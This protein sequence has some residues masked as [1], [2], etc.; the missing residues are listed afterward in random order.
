MQQQITEHQPT[1]RKGGERQSEHL[2][3]W[4]GG[5]RLQN[6]RKEEGTGV[7]RIGRRQAPKGSVPSLPGHFECWS[8][9]TVPEAGVRG[10][11]SVGRGALVCEPRLSGTAASGS[12]GD[13][14]ASFLDHLNNHDLDLE[15]DF[16]LVQMT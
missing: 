5:G 2:R 12:R 14:A 8:P 6:L 3:R 9:E 11:G 4:G 15:F 7:P 1:R 13:G 16:I 10:D